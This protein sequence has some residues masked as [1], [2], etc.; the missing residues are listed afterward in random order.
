MENL[1]ENSLYKQYNH[2]HLLSLYQYHDYQVML[3]AFPLVLPDFPVRVRRSDSFLAGLSDYHD[4]SDSDYNEDYN[5]AYNKD[6]SKDYNK[7][8]KKD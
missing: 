5:N 6:Y 2:A 7:V 4:D 1:R 3:G 8:F